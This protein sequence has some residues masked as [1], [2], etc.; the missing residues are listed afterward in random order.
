MVYPPLDV[1]ANNISPPPPTHTIQLKDE[2][3][4][5]VDVIAPPDFVLQS[6]IGASDG[7]VTIFLCDVYTHRLYTPVTN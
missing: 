4:S 5:L 2:A 1:L 3:V 7:Q 6:P